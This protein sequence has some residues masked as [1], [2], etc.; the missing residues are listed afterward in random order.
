MGGSNDP[1]A[2]AE[3]HLGANFLPQLRAIARTIATKGGRPDHGANVALKMSAWAGPTDASPP[4]FGNDGDLSTDFASVE[5][6][7]DVPWW[8]VDLGSEKRISAVQIVL[9]QTDHD[10]KYRTEMQVQGSNE[11]DFS[12]FKVIA[13]A[14]EGAEIPPHGSFY[15][16][17][18]KPARFRYIRVSRPPK[19]YHVFWW[20]PGLRFSECRVF[21]PG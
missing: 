15:A 13:W 20:K 14:M 2:S 6:D 1:D 19:N 7:S 17:V 8:Q 4:A 11:P 3:G 18:V 16:F 21:G 12:T 5:N 10:K 9:S